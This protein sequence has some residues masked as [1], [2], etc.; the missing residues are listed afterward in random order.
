MGLMGGA[1]FGTKPRELG[2]TARL[3]GGREAIVTTGM[4]DGHTLQRG[5]WCSAADALWRWHGHQEPVSE[6]VYAAILQAK[7]AGQV[8]CGVVTDERLAK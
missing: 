3:V 2:H 1:M 4:S 6:Y 8:S 7:E 5:A